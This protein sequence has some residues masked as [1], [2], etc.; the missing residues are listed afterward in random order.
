MR[1]LL[2][3]IQGTYNYGCE[4]IVRGTARIL[5]DM[6]P[7]IQIDYVSPGRYVNDTCRLQ[8]SGVNVIKCDI[9]TRLKY[10]AN[11]IFKMIKLPYTANVF[12]THFLK[13]YNAV[14]SIG[15]DIYTIWS[16][17]GY[18]RYLVE[19]GDLCEKINVPYVLWGC[20]VG[21]FE[22][23]LKIKTIFQK[24]LKNIS[25]IVA[26]EQ[27]T[28]NYLKSL[29]IEHNVLFS[30]DPAF[31]VPTPH[32]N[33][34]ENKKIVGINLSPLSLK[35]LKLEEKD[36]VKIHAEI[37]S[38]LMVK[39]GYSIF[40]LP[41]VVECADGDND[42]YYLRKVY[43]AIPSHLKGQVTL[44]DNDPG[45]IGLKEYIEQCKVVIAARMHCG[46]NSVAT[47]TPALFLSY[48]EKSKGMSKL[49]YGSTD[50]CIPLS[51]FNKD[52]IDRI[53]QLI[54]DIKLDIELIDRINDKI[55]IKI[56]LEQLLKVTK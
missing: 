23:N 33:Q 6:F 46:I 48:S 36:C 28:I 55:N 11:K 8:G 29:G 40:L 5:R 20:S 26:R 49:V 56:A 19:L 43:E 17:G 47:G 24:H 21:P 44:V 14:F 37:L 35:Y 3:G 51:Q 53:E 38:A 10:Y 39:Y 22:N 7:D 41:H 54:T 12:T 42:L 2:T 13:K 1:V 30:F 16:D 15:G 18:A 32:H 25:L 34:K 50:Y 52:N 9:T 27:V 31:S 4:A 45:F